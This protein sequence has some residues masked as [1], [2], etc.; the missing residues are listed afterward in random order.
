MIW[1]L[2]FL[3]KLFIRSDWFDTV[4]PCNR[5]TTS[6]LSL[7]HTQHLF[8][9][10]LLAIFLTVRCEETAVIVVCTLRKGRFLQF[11]NF[12]KGFKPFPSH[13]QVVYIQYM[14]NIFNF[15]PNLIW[16]RNPFILY[17]RPAPFWKTVCQNEF[18]N[19]QR[20]DEQQNHS[21]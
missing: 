9:F 10:F 3:E 2:V 14:C 4:G 12:E 17:Q 11:W 19:N 1:L 20:L 15:T 18:L 7:S 5:L 8:V 16:C 6:D 13:S 21:K